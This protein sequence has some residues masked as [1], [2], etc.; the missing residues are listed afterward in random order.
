MPH[1]GQPRHSDRAQDSQRTVLSLIVGVLVLAAAY[2][3][4][5]IPVG[6]DSAGTIGGQV[7]LVTGL[8][9]ALIAVQNRRRLNP[10]A[11][12]W[13]LIAAG[14]I[15][16]SSAHFLRDSSEPVDVLLYTGLFMLT[17]L[18]LIA[19]CLRMAGSGPTRSTWRQLTIDLVPPIIA[20]L[21]VAWLIEIG[22]FVGSQDVELHFQV[23]A[24]LHGLAAVALTVVGL[25][26]ILS[27]RQM[28]AHPAVQS[29]MTGLTILAIADGFWLQRWID[30][31]I[32]FGVA[33]DVAFCIGF[34]TIAI[35]GLQARLGVG[36]GKRIGA[37]RIVPL[38]LVQKTTPISLLVLLSFAG[39]QAK[40]GELTPDGILIAIV[41]GLLLVLFVMMSEDLLA[42]RETVLSEE[43]DT[44]SERIDGLI[45][46][47]G[48]DPLTGLMNRRAF[49]ERLEHEIIAGRAT[50]RPVAIALIDVDN[51]KRVNDTLGH[52]VGDQVLQAVASVLIGACR[53]SDSAARYA[54]DEFV[55]ILPGVD[56]LTAGEVSRRIGDSV[57]RVNDQL[58]PLAD[59]AV[60][61]SI[62][63]AVTYRC[64]RN[65]AQLVAIADAAMYDAKEGGKN[66]VVA[67]DADTLMTSAYW[68]ADPASSATSHLRIAATDRRRPVNEYSSAQ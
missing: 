46:Q 8:V 28:R 61:L 63:V 9:S 15:I 49:Q 37:K 30:R 10:P 23:A 26:G 60:T 64:K 33:A 4:W 56:E 38:R 68:G 21:T 31:D 54:G 47:V 50:G 44:L 12:G 16:W 62:G 29:V 39:G 34:A 3:A 22:P 24:I 18:A 66:Q 14:S 41:A 40:W 57:L 11:P 13:L 58:T 6:T 32:S 7:L 2:L 17:A 27:W 20:L 59:I 48:R 45:S 35:G 52:A 53:A 67:V 36:A 51:F 1:V 43:I 19:G 25:V 42:K 65:V 55:M 5:R